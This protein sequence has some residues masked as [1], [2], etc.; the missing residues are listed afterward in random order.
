MA[1]PGPGAAQQTPKSPEARTKLRN[2]NLPLAFFLS[3]LRLLAFSWLLAAV[4]EPDPLAAPHEE[5]MQS[6]MRNE[7]QLRAIR[8]WISGAPAGLLS[9]RMSS[10]LLCEV[11][12]RRLLQTPFFRPRRT[13]GP[14][15]SDCLAPLAPAS[16]A[17]A[18]SITSNGGHATFPQKTSHAMRPKSMGV[19]HNAFPLEKEIKERQT[20]NNANHVR[21][22]GTTHGRP[23]LTPTLTFTP[24]LTP[25]TSTLLSHLPGPSP[26]DLCPAPS[27]LS[28]SPA[29]SADGT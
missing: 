21:N 9:S 6:Q 2:M 19:W 7:E 1:T 13:W 22:E 4:R 14:A 26:H 8:P 18:A 25:S 15:I 11:N 3:C 29:T 16:P 10:A 24:T 27:R 17:A 23:T 5:P 12:R 20:K 28:P